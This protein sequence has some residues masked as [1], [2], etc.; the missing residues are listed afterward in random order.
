M[1][2]PNFFIIGAPKCGTTALSE[3]LR[4]HPQVFMTD[5]KEPCFFCEDFPSRQKFTSESEYLELFR[6]A[7]AR[8]KAVGEASVHYL[9]SQ[10]AVPAIEARFPSAK[11]IVMLRNPVDFLPSF[12]SQMLRNLTEDVE[13]FEAAWALTALRRKGERVPKGCGEPALLDYRAAACFGEQVERLLRHVDRDRV[14]FIRFD[15]F[16]RHTADL[17]KST[18]DFLGV[19]HDGRVDFPRVNERAR[20]RSKMLAYW[21]PRVTRLRRRLGISNDSSARRIMHW[22]AVR[23]SEWNKKPSERYR[24]PAPLQSELVEEFAADVD[25]LAECTGLDLRTWQVIT[26]SARTAKETP[27]R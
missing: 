3:Y 20:S 19:D 2:P 4:E 1:Q 25:K 17:Y 8:H 23:I 14:M 22:A 27:M 16:T 18:L 7:D 13:D 5:P 10:V 11:Y 6:D 24:M 21:V 15:D 26:Q 9:R 12:H